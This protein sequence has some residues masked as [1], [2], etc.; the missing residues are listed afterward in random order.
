MKGDSYVP[1]SAG[2]LPAHPS[3]DLEQYRKL[4]KDLVKACRS[5]NGTAI[6]AWAI[7]WLDRLAMLQHRPKTLQKADDIEASAGRVEEF[8]RKQFSVGKVFP[9]DGAVRHRPRAWFHE[10]SRSSRVI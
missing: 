9:V 10:A 8:A 7:R 3:T 4:A 6:R 1:V 5:G 2:C